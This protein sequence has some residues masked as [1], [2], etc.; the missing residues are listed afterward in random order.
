ADL[1]V[2]LTADIDLADLD[3][4]EKENF[5]IN[6]FSGVF[7]GKNHVVKN[8][9]S[10]GSL[11]GSMSGTLRNLTVEGTIT[12]HKATDT[13]GG[14]V[15]QNSGRVENCV[16]KVKITC[17][18]AG[19]G[20]VAAP[21]C[22]VGGISGINSGIIER[23]VN[24]GDIELTGR[25][26]GG[27]A[28]NNGGEISQCEN[29]ANI[30]CTVGTD[31]HPADIGGIAAI[32][33]NVIR[34]CR[35]SGAL[36]GE[37]VEK[38]GSQISTVLSVGG[39]V[40]SGCK[41]VYG[42]YS[43]G[44]I[45]LDKSAGEDRLVKHIGAVV[46]QGWDTDYP[47]RK[48]EL[49]GNYYLAGIRSED[50][51]QGVGT[52]EEDEENAV[53][54]VA[55]A[56][57]LTEQDIW[58]LNS[59]CGYVAGEGIWALS[60]GE[61]A[62]AGDGGAAVYKVSV[63]PELRDYVRLEHGSET[64]EEGYA[65]VSGKQ[66]FRIV[67]KKDGYTFKKL[68]IN[69]ENE[70]DS[71]EGR[72]AYRLICAG[73]YDVSVDAELDGT[74]PVS[75]CKKAIEAI[76]T[77]TNRNERAVRDARRAY[78]ELFESDRQE[79]GDAADTLAEAERA[80][81]FLKR[82]SVT[83][84]E[85]VYTSDGQGKEPEA[86]VYVSD[87]NG[88]TEKKLLAAGKDYTVSYEN[89]IRPGTAT[90]VVT[91]V[92]DYA[93]PG[94]YLVDFT[95]SQPKQDNT[96]QNKPD[97]GSTGQDKPDNGQPQPDNGSRETDIRSA[98]IVMKKSYTHTG[99]ALTPAMTVKLG[100]TVLKAGEDYTAAYKNNKEPG[101]ATVTVSG[102]GKYS[103][104]AETIFII[105]AAKGKTYTVGSLEYKVT[106]ANAAKGTVSVSGVKRKTVKS[107]SVPE[108][109]KIGNY[110][111]TV[112]AIGSNAF[113]NCKSLQKAAIGKNVKQIGS[114]AF[115]GDKKLKTITVKGK[116]LSGVGKNALKGIA[117]KAV[118]KVPSSKLV[119][120]KKL[121]KNKGQ[122]KTVKVRK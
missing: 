114:G 97:Q 107:V 122:A 26:V 20:S 5:R 57:K 109:V 69:G 90:A 64:C 13:L 100:D 4:T 22:R 32:T 89:N 73:G 110:S 1:D 108:K 41:T 104:T 35:N 36:V 111:Y 10:D 16:N 39:I 15:G 63:S 119:S 85:T 79:L 102:T 101:T 68:A 47:G 54:S 42:N 49:Y 105:K 99:K 58:N 96:D 34:Y 80:S 30:D 40:G 86:E 19:N 46:G 21:Y 60:G 116:S 112:T 106:K 18:D 88:Q 81:A 75:D 45:S 84:K 55:D 93:S 76:G 78:D 9:Q 6:S 66:K 48:M 37:Y 44:S 52:W 94:K 24:E 92:G 82:V 103:G 38:Q 98:S 87:P 43:E 74:K 67:I 65:Y 118:V 33:S 31:T 70:S 77:V 3:E 113:K 59:G 11:F 56:A 23:C 72:N 17:T 8:F 51:P 61:L 115:Y 50:C 71:A 29:R 2:E 83:L 62:Y 53:I 7:D 95:I 14:V 28:G 120:Y 12:N 117:D 25:Y 91:F 27:I 121:F